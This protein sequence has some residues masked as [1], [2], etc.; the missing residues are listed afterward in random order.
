MTI[1]IFA[2]NVYFTGIYSCESLYTPLS[3]NGCL[4][5]SYDEVVDG[6]VTSIQKFGKNILHLNTQ[7][8]LPRFFR[9]LSK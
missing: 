9:R 5:E 3:S 6:S 2:N 8:F 7:I 4:I 1:H